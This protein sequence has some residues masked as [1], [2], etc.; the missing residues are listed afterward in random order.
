MKSSYINIR[1]REGRLRSPALTKKLMTEPLTK[2]QKQILDYITEF[3]GLHGYAPSYEEIGEHMGLTSKATVFEHVR[4]LEDKGYIKAAPKKA[5]AIDLIEVESTHLFPHSM[6]AVELPLVGLITAGEPIEA[7]QE[8]E[9]ITVPTSLVRDENSFVLKVKGE[10]MID[11]GILDGDYVI[12]ER[13]FYPH[14]GDVVVALLD[15]AYATLKKYYREK[16]R[17]RLQPANSTMKPIYAKNP[18]VQGIVRA[19]LRK[20]STI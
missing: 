14:N 17:I 18:T 7:I 16:N 15:N 19:V 3:I 12:V 4:N 2:R 8:N 11:D 9:M 10:S 1:K 20:Y 5:R 13:N 6:Q